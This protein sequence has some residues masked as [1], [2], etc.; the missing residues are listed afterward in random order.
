M[1]N[2]WKQLSLDLKPYGHQVAR[3]DL[4]QF[5]QCCP[6]PLKKF[7]ESFNRE[8]HSAAPVLL[9]Y[10]MG[11]RLALHVLL[12]QPDKWKKA[13]IV[14]AHTGLQPEER[15]PRLGSDAGW[16]AKA[17][18]GSWADFL[19]EWNGQGVLAGT[20]MP[21]RSQLEIRREAVARSFMDWSVGAQEDLLP[22]L[23]TVK[24]PVLWVA[25]EQDEK[26]LR[27]AEKAV[28]ALPRGELCVVPDCGHRAP[29]EKPEFFSSKVKEF[30]E[31]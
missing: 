4:W 18:K 14:S 6:M 22:H 11:G 20:N 25:G 1:A 9:G 29:W 10:S 3:V 31:Q 24:C 27:V 15:N 23:N 19:K 8:V 5:L 30:L 17:L 12:N 21:D 2:D 28:Q 16:A 7:G 26:F 13:V